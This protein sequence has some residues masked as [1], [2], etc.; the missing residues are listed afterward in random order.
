MNTTTAITSLLVNQLRH[1]Y[2]VVAP[3]FSW[4]METSRLGAA[5]AAYRLRV[6]EGREGTGIPV[7]D[8]G[9]VVT[10]K[11]LAI[12]Y[13]GPALKSASAYSWRVLVKDELG[14]WTE[15]G[16]AVFE[17]ALADAAAW[18]KADWIS[19]DDPLRGDHDT[20]AF[21][22]S[23]ANSG[24]VREAWWFVT[25]LGVFEAYVNGE[26]VSHLCGCGSKIRD[27]LKPGFTHCG[28][29][30]HYFSYDITHLVKTGAGAA[31]HLSA[32]V[33]AGWW[34]DQITGHAGKESAFRAVLVLRYAD[35]SEE[36]IGTDSSW[37][38]TY[39]GPVT[40]ANIFYGEDF[41]A[42]VLAGWK[43]RLANPQDR[44]WPPARVN[45]EFQGETLPLKGLPIRQRDDIALA[46]VSIRVWSGIEGADAE[47]FGHI[48]V[49]R[50]YMDGDEMKLLPGENLQVDFGQNAAAVPDFI[51]E[52]DRGTRLRVRFAEMLND[53]NGAF[54]RRND[55]PEGELYKRNYRDARSEATYIFAGGGEEAYRPTFTFFGYRYLS[56]SATN[57]VVTIR[58]VRSVPVTSVIKC[59]ETGSIETGV[60]LVNRLIA[61]GLWGLRSNYLSIPT[62]CPQRNE[63]LGWAA[64]TQVF[65][66]AACY[67]ANV[68]SFLSKWMDDMND[69]QHPDGGYPGV[70]PIAQYGDNSAAVGW[71]DAAIIVPHVL[72]RMFGDTSVIDD[73]YSGMVKYLDLLDRQ[74]GPC[75]EPWGEWLAY[76]RNDA[77][78][79]RYL[80]CAYWVWDAMLMR[81]MAAAIG[82]KADVRR[83]ADSEA[84]ARA[85]F[86]AKYLDGRGEIL[87]DF[88]CQAAA[89]FALYLDL[90]AGEA[91]A[92][93]R[94]ELLDN[95]TAHGNCLQTG[96]LGTA[97]ILHTL[98]KVGAPETAYT[99]L[100]QHKNPSWLY[101]VD[102][103]ATTFWERWNSY[104]KEAG[105]GDA[106]MNS[107]NHYAYGSIISWM[108]GA[109]AGIRE[110]LAAPGFSHFFL[111]PQPDRR[112][113][114]V[115]AIYDSASGRI[116]SA[117][118]YDASGAWTWRYTVPAN[119]TATVILP[120]GRTFERAAGSYMEK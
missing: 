58:R 10:A 14:D 4:K 34:R 86:R 26:P 21:I 11:S 22:K 16:A 117:W 33:S 81:E 95:I 69:S 17:T 118:E 110:D 12:R 90:V 65:A 94:Q 38:A 56:I 113:G 20:A 48:R 40:K 55:G 45:T 92:K 91:F 80:A 105:F 39:A 9:E 66:P 116:A 109:M 76:E 62:D 2:G 25:G 35:G 102:Q 36:T 97:I 68:Y 15:S 73:H 49:L 54:S 85:V 37:R 43:E 23:V 30:R 99:L 79:K 77:E 103:G 67:T 8:S 70:A 63:R 59:A 27:A 89:L 93:T 115:K 61:N 52:A 60:P 47:H 88:K 72:W 87:P 120:D 41:D 83:F 119:T 53:G 100:L 82:R 3:S 64:D 75:P 74:E 7:W 5:Q 24:T 106:G 114:S 108:Y 31:N 71:A 51:F 13:A 32:L 96:F 29:R 111:Q 104:T 84:R 42:R 101:S 28:K 1:A 57:G 18:K 46:P 19:V 44:A 6:F 50:T 98:G 112:V 78:I 107:F